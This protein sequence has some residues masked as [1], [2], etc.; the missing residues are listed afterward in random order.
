MYSGIDKATYALDPVG[1]GANIPVGSVFVES[2]YEQETAA[3]ATFK[4]WRRN[5]AGATT[6]VSAASTATSVNGTSYIFTVRETLTTG[7]GWSAPKTVTVTGNGTARIA[8]LIPA[9]LSAAGV[10]NV[11][12]TF[13]AASNKLTMRHNLGGDIALTD[14]LNGPLAAAGFT[15]YNMTTKTGTVN[16][17]AG[18]TGIDVDFFATNW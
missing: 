16:L 17:Y 9:A 11:T 4:L 6:I 3:A 10:V 18:P 7:S 2:N 12:S 1:G 8:A 14:G 5:G 15:A 13:D